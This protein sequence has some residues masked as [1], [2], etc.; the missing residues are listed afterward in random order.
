MDQ[1]KKTGTRTLLLSVLLSAP[2]PL[3]L[4]LGLRVGHSSTQIS[5][6]TRRTAELLALVVAFIV[7]VMTNRRADMGEARKRDLERNGNRFSGVIMCLSGL[8]MIL[9]TLLSGS[10]DKGNVI[11][12]LAVAFLGVVANVL[13]WRKYTA[14]YRAQKNAI[15][16]VQARLYGAKSAV[17]ICVTLALLA[18]LAFPG[19][20]A[21][22]WIDRVGSLLV[23]LY[24]I[25]CGVRTVLEQRR[26][27][28]SE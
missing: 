5:D 15:L 1:E 4:G 24:M 17:D 2:G 6:F 7:Y 12:A 13:F 19:T 10:E 3:I 20:A 11:P 18:V 14:L 27:S 8:S 21:S 28:A 26:E 25:R 16:G 22:Y 23:S 9:V